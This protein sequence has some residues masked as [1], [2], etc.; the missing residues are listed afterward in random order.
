MIY[1]I[2]Y[3]FVYD[4]VNDFVNDFIWFYMISYDFIWLYPLKHIPYNDPKHMVRL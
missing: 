4:F 3:D 1:M 2:L